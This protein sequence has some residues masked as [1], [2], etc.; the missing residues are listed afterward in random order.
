[1]LFFRGKSVLLMSK[2]SFLSVIYVFP[3]EWNNS[4]ETSNICKIREM[5]KLKLVQMYLWLILLW[6]SSQY[7]NI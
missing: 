4:F 6:T 7:E 3:N 2:I 5:V 1:M